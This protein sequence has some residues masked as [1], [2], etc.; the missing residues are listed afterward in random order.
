MS[1]SCVVGWWATSTW[2]PQY[3]GQ[4]AAR[5]GLDAQQWAGLTGLIY[6]D[7]VRIAFLQTAGLLVGGWLLFAGFRGG[8]GT[9]K[10]AGSWVYVDPLHLYEAYREQGHGAGN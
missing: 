6:K 10:I 1:L 8:K 5:A 4:N 3:A 7:P 9:N 2:I